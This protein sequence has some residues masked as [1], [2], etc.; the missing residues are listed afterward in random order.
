MS[1]LT[2]II[3]KYIFFINKNL[4]QL[5]T[6]INDIL[7]Q[8][9][10]L[11]GPVIITDSETTK[12]SI[13]N[14]SLEVVGGAGIGADA[15]V[16]YTLTVLGSENCL[17]SANG[18]TCTSN[19]AL[20]VLNG[21][22][23]INKSICVNEQVVVNSGSVTQPA[24]TFCH[25]ASSGMFRL[26]PRTINLGITGTEVIRVTP[27]TLELRNPGAGIRINDTGSNAT[28]GT[29]TFLSAP[30]VTVFSGSVISSLGVVSQ[31]FITP[32]NAIG[33]LSV[34]NVSSGSFT[35]TS[36]NPVETG[37]VFWMIINPTI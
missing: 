22:A 36:S 23:Y 29:A 31:I 2:R 7:F 21:G 19:S 9:L 28:V 8:P 34:T 1:D 27:S 3:L 24:Y 4:I 11:S 25:E 14:N 33:T 35:V 5:S 37:M 6:R 10:T 15:T 16:G 12:N 13:A 18:G 32:Y 26:A 20:A 17:T 30:F